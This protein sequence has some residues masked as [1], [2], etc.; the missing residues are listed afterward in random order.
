M[1]LDFLQKKGK[2]Q[3]KLD[4]AVSGDSVEVWTWGGDAE[5]AAGLEKRGMV[6]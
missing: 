2:Q 6:E 5:D 3:A 1:D 4:V